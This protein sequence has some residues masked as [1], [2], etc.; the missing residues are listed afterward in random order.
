[1]KILTA[2]CLKLKRKSNDSGL[3]WK[4]LSLSAA[5]FNSRQGKGLATEYAISF[6]FVFLL[7]LLPCQGKSQNDT[8]KKVIADSVVEKLHSAKK[9]TIMSAV[10]PGLGQ[11]YNKKYWKVPIIYAGIGVF[12]YFIVFNANNYNRFRSAYIVSVN[13]DTAN[14]SDLTQ[15]YTSDELL[16]ARDY[17]RRNLEMTCL[18]TTLWYILNILDATVDAHLFTYNISKELSMKVEP[19]FNPIYGS[20]VSSGVK[21]SFKF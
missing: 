19:V 2:S 16:S 15:K 21:L 4:W 6:I 12:T 20:R 7:T 1:M 13:K 9:A 11:V 5:C 8:I 14:Y 10:L 3:P 17:Y 18:L